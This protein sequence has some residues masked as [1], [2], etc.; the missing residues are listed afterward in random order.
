MKVLFGNSIQQR[1]TTLMLIISGVALLLSS[2][3]FII[4][5]F[6]SFRKNMVHDLSTL[7][8]IIGENSSSALVFDDSISAENTLSAL[9]AKTHIHSA[10]LFTK[11]G[12]IFARFLRDT[13]G[14]IPSSI[15]PEKTGYRF[16]I[17]TLLLFNDIVLHGERIGSI[18]IQADL[19]ELY[20]RLRR[21][22]LMVLLVT[23]VAGGVVF[24]LARRLQRTISEPILHL[25]AVAKTVSEEKN[26][27]V[28]ATGEQRQDEFGILFTGFNEMLS[29]IQSRDNKLQEYQEH[30]EEQVS[31]RTAL[32]TDMNID[33]TAA[34][35]AALEA[36][37][38]KSAFL[39][40]MSHELRTPLNAIIGYSEMLIEQLEDRRDETI[41]P[42]LNKIQG[43]GKH[44]LELIS[45]ILD[46][47]KIEAGKISLHLEIFDLYAMAKEVVQLMQPLMLTNKNSL[48]L[49]CPKEIGFFYGDL[50]KVRQT[51]LNLLSNASKFTEQGTITFEV[52]REIQDEA[53]QVLITVS[54]TGIGMTPEQTKKLFQAFVQADVS[55]TRKFGGT[56]L[57][58]AISRHYCRMMGGDITVESE[59][60]NGSTFIVNLPVIPAGLR[61]VEEKK[62]EQM[63]P[64]DPQ[65]GSQKNRRGGPSDRRESERARS[66]GTEIL[67]RN[68][69]GGG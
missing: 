56:G 33:L 49:L 12:E 54:D 14:E 55:T 29:Q 11:E 8:Q 48:V 35:D 59:L 66:V 19:D 52:G 1:I 64:Q 53:E 36:T 57:G 30:L 16:E 51:V 24:L 58:L 44:L 7:T 32:L 27:T 61:A 4:N 3:V 28:R 60:N 62:D 13:K 31:V 40:N 67:Q 23:M 69:L 37:K 43:A 25:S 63:I 68:L 34:R 46:I 65:R 41:I 42:D 47:S 20:S 18:L 15:K 39:A 2:S 22:G 9:R 26:Y 5:D 50:T 38:I 45:E 21:Y 10:I 17:N 6:F